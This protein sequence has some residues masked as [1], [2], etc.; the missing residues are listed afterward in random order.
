MTNNPKNFRFP[1]SFT[2]LGHKYRIKFVSD[3][4][5]KEDAYGYYDDDT[6]LIRIQST[7]SLQKS[8]EIGGGKTEMV[9][10]VVTD[11]AVIEAF[12]HELMH[13]I[14][15]ALEESTLSEN[16]RFVGLMGKALLEIYL[17]SEYEEPSKPEA[18]PSD[19]PRVTVE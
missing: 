17:Y 19:N 13:A 16:E 2:L 1:K 3:L 11:E 7:G 4:Y 10:F 15:D 8:V 12:F 18:T 5:H 14:L 9:E 6:K